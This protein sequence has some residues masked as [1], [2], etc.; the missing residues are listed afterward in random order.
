MERKSN[1]FGLRR[2]ALRSPAAFGFH[3]ALMLILVGACITWLWSVNGTV[4]LVRGQEVKEFVTDEGKETIFPFSLTLIDSRVEYHEATTAPK[5]FVSELKVVCGGIAEHKRVSMN[6]V[7]EIEGYRFCQ[8]AMDTDRSTLTVNY[9]PWGIAVTYAGYFLLFGASVLMLSQWAWRG[10]KGSKRSVAVLMLIAVCSSAFGGRVADDFGRLRV[11]WGNRPAPVESMATDILNKVYGKS[12]YKGLSSTE[13][14]I[15]WLFNYDYWKREPII[16]V[17]GEEVKKA[18]G[19]KGR[20][21]RLTDFFGPGGYKLQPLLN[22]IGDKNVQEAHERV[23]LIT[24]LCTGQLLRIFPYKSALGRQ[25]WL[26]SADMKPSKMELDQWVLITQ[27]VNNLAR[28]MALDDKDGAIIAISRIA[29]YQKEQLPAL[30]DKNLQLELCYNRY[31]KAF[32]PACIAFVA[33]LFGCFFAERYRWYIRI[34]V[35]IVACGLFAYLSAMIALRG[36]VAGHLPLSN[37]YETMQAMGWIAALGAVTQCWRRPGLGAMFL[38]V[39][40]MALMVNAMSHGGASLSPLLPVLASPLLSVHVLLIM[41]AYTLLA[42]VMLNSISALSMRTPEKKAVATAISMRLLMPAVVFLACGIF[43]GA[44]WANQSWGRY[45][46]WDPKETWALITL[47]IYSLPFHSRWARF[48]RNPLSLNIY[49]S[50][51]FLSVL[52]TYFGVN[53]FLGGL[54]SYA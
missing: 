42:L 27:S 17:K 48:F 41:M 44:I 33:G 1:C 37:G 26:S 19:I 40:G 30:S 49:L 53:F 16:K 23:M 18:L 2:W 22:N 15:G 7:L 43:V 45:W 39:G 11:Y 14:A 50:V 9:D 25:E 31:N 3:V 35:T 36:A 21:A 32:L 29:Q 5:D 52:M 20:Y 4:T 10:L 6:R 13:V 24:S 46:G 34:V 47:L 54:H 38:I 51:A 28:S 12:E 8:K